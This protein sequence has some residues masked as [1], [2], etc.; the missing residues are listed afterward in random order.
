VKKPI[1][2]LKLDRALGR[3]CTADTG[4]PC[5]R[6]TGLLR[7]F[8]EARPT[9]FAFLDPGDLL[10][11]KTSGFAGIP[12]WDSFAEHYATCERCHA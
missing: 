1:D 4:I 10:D 3:L 2:D 11:L 8:A 6:V 9:D 12:E 7:S 5:S